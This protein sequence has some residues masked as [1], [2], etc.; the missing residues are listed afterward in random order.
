MSDFHSLLP[1]AGTAVMIDELV[2]WD[3]REI[4]A[5]TR[6]H[7]SRDNPL[8][9]E[10]R[11]AAVHLVEYGAQAMAAHGALRARADHREP[12]SALLVSVREFEALRDFIE[13]LPD[14]LEILARE[15]LSS[16]TGWQYEF[17]VWHGSERIARGRV[18]ALAFALPP[19]ATAGS[20]D[21]D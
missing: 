19:Q 2:R 6:T 1:H 13:D 18:A 17:E 7:Q 14:P 5:R 20:N 16:P 10:G 11:L 9:R 4:R 21:P 8:R 12:V 3:E 15:L